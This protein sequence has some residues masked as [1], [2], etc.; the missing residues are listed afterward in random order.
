MNETFWCCSEL[1]KMFFFRFQMY[2]QNYRRIPWTRYCL[3]HIFIDSHYLI[4]LFNM[5]FAC[6]W[7]AYNS[8]IFLFQVQIVFYISSF[9]F[10]FHFF[11]LLFDLVVFSV[12]RLYLTIYVSSIEK[13]ININLL[14]FSRR[15]IIVW[16]KYEHAKLIIT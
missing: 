2:T 12:Q 1:L 8:R 16:L 14:T 11:I 9:F 3:L 7:F 13:T 10:S 6:Y 4:G 5:F 15:H